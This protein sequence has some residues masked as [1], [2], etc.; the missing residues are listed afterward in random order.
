[1]GNRLWVGGNRGWY[2]RISQT[3]DEGKWQTETQA[4]PKQVLALI[5]SPRTLG[6]CETFAKEISRHI[7]E[8]HALKLLRLTSLKIRPC[9]A[10]YGC[11]MGNPCPEEDDMQFLLGELAGADAVILS[12]PVYYLGANAMIKSVCDRGFLF[13]SILEKTYG[14]PII[15]LNFFGIPERIG[16]APQMLETF[17]M[18]LGMSV[19]VSLSIQAALPGEALMNEKNL[20]LAHRLG[21]TLFSSGSIKPE[22]GCPFCTSQII[23]IAEKDFICTVCHGSFAINADGSFIKMKDGGI[24]GPP[25]HMLHHRE[26]LCGMKKKFQENKKKIIQTIAGYK[27]DGDW[28]KPPEKT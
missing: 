18:F 27:N 3:M 14:K 28:I 23:R 21:Q 26:W 6:N 8:P 15:L 17:A 20:A 10:C 16:M 13:F 1:M 12:S 2:Y 22:R 9:R 25:E 7:P 5:A 4:T 19:K 11:V 24:I